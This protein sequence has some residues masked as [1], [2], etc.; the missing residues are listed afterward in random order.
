MWRAIECK[1]GGQEALDLHTDG[2]I[3]LNLLD[4]VGGLEGLRHL[5]RNHAP[6]LHTVPGELGRNKGEGVS[7]DITSKG[8]EVQGCEAVEV[9]RDADRHMAAIV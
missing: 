1:Y 8:S 3:V 6:L 2:E 4:D 5:L 9:C 7:I